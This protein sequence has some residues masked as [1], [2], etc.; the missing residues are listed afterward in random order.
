MRLIGIYHISLDHPFINRADSCFF[1]FYGEN[2]LHQVILQSKL[3]GCQKIC[4]HC[5]LKLC[6]ENCKVH[7]ICLFEFCE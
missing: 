1:K 4:C 2:D 7:M 5:L 3:G 6:W